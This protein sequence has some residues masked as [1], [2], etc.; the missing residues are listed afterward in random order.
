M[1]GCV[2][3]EACGQYPQELAQV[4]FGALGAKGCL[5]QSQHGCLTSW[6]EIG[7]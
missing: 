1:S 6:S 2:G 5:T 3:G 4:P 7:I